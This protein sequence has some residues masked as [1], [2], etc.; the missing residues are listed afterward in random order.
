M[1]ANAVS[2]P[3]GRDISAAEA[4][5]TAP[6]DNGPLDKITFADVLDALNPLQYVPV[7][8]TIYRVVTGDQGSPGLRT[9]L[10]MVTGALTGGP[11]GLLTSIA[12]TLVERLFH[13]EQAA[14]SMLAPAAAGQV[15]AK[16]A[17]PTHASAEAD[18]RHVPAS[19]V[20]SAAP[21]PPAS[22]LTPSRAP[23][24]APGRAPDPALHRAPDPAPVMT[25]VARGA[26]AAYA[27]A[28]ANARIIWGGRER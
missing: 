25:G 21:A 3:H 26:V 6:V 28:E 8:G 5:S 15:A 24:R 12:S 23:G 7:V 14:R 17:A 18:L 11:V 2:G 19:T 27:R 22:G 13:V 4:A 20:T 9:A 1:A 16:A 10:S